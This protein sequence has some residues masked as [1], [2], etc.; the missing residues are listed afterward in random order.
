MHPIIDIIKKFHK[1][2]SKFKTKIDFAFKFQ[3]RDLDTYIEKKFV[4]SDHKGVRRFLDTKLSENSWKK[5]ISNC[6][7]FGFKTICTPF[8]EISV[9]RIIK[10]KFEYLKIASCSVNEW[11]L[12]QHIFKKCKNQKV[13]SSLGGATEQQIRNIIV[14]FSKKN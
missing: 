13:I 1:I 12:L 4:N 6:K 14:F 7:R 11:P 5:I 8:D 9:D 2:S 3:F 10:N